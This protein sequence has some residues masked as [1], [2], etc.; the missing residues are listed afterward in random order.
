MDCQLKLI[1]QYSINADCSDANDLGMRDSESVSMV[2]I[3]C[4]RT[5]HTIR[6]S[7]AVLFATFIDTMS[8]L[9]LSFIP[10]CCL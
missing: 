6:R 3:A 10:Y 1:V 5:A 7:L 2:R 4:E 9:S 8:A